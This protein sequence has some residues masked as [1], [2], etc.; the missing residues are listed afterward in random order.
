M[1]ARTEVLLGGSPHDPGA[2]CAGSSVSGYTHP[3]QHRGHL[4]GFGCV[5]GLSP[6]V[7]PDGGDAR[8][9]P[10]Q[11]PRDDASGSTRDARRS[12]RQA[13]ATPSPP[14]PTRSWRWSGPE[15][16]N[17][18]IAVVPGSVPDGTYN[19]PSGS[20]C[21]LRSDR[22][23]QP[24]INRLRCRRTDARKTTSK[25]RLGDRKGHRGKEYVLTSS[26]PVAP[27][28]WGQ[29]VDILIG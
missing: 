5:P 10:P 13:R 8:S 6:G 2:R 25:S 16:G 18:K 12:R 28:H 19:R 3:S 15:T 29:A 4:R 27:R 24:R 20:R 23:K 26:N 22:P 14:A 9:P 1:A 17:T 7:A 11:P 21:A